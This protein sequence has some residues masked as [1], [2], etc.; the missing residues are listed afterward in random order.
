MKRIPLEV[1]K[2]YPIN[3]EEPDDALILAA[4][5]EERCLGLP[6]LLN[7][8]RSKKI[9]LSI[10]DGPSRLRQK[11]IEELRAILPNV[12]TLCEIDAQHANPLPN[13]RETIKIIR[14][15]SETPSPRLSI[16]ISTFTRKHLLQLLQGLDHA[17]MLETSNLYYT[18]PLD[19]HTPDDEPV[20]QGISSVKAIETFAGQNN[21]SRDSLLILFLSYEG[22]RALALWEHLEPNITLAVI[23]DPPYRENWRNRT[24]TQNRYLL[25]CLPQDRIFKTHSLCSTATEQFLTQLMRGELYNIDKYNYRIAPMGTRAQ[26]LG[27]YRFWRKHLGLPTLVYASPVRYREE[28]ATF[29]PGRTWLLDTP[30]LWA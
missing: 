2:I 29:S 28:R 7:S 30:G 19:Y 11:N 1:T 5:W 9:I 4:S 10:Y 8:Y 21:P 18:E 6:R 17:K 15:V 20:S 12:G 13:I 25:S 3:S 23:A 27:V 26:T 24:E 22:R 16:D 14:E